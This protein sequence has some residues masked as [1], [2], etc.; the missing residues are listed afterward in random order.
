[1]THLPLNIVDVEFEGI[2]PVEQLENMRL[3][4]WHSEHC[5]CELD[6]LY[7][8]GDSSERL[9]SATAIQNGEGAFKLLVRTRLSVPM[10]LTFL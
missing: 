8:G 3:E 5:H 7:V 4:Q 6:S 10:G 9:L 2:V 1:M